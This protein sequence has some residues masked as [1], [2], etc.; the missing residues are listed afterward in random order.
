MAEKL[1]ELRLESNKPDYL[2]RILSPFN[3]WPLNKIVKL[4]LPDEDEKQL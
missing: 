1:Y 3:I 2:R 4:P